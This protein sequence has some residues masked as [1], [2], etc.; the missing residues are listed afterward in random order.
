MRTA[1]ACLCAADAA[2]QPPRC[3]Q[4]CGGWVVG[5]W[6][7]AGCGG[8]QQLPPPACP[9]PSLTLPTPALPR[10]CRSRDLLA[11]CNPQTRL[12]CK[13]KC[14]RFLTDKNNCGACG[15]KCKNGERGAACGR[16]RSRGGSAGR[17]AASSSVQL[18]AGLEHRL[19][20]RPFPA[21]RCPTNCPHPAAA[22]CCARQHLRQRRLRVP[23]QPVRVLQQVHRRDARQH[24]L[25]LLRQCLPR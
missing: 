13:G 12:E 22:P 21:N 25:R 2:D 16:G 19:S 9:A 6:D 4:P 8:V 20:F 15:T 5:S 1:V 7:P 23:R 18:G 11:T 24:E 17:G 3:P 14:V 10:R